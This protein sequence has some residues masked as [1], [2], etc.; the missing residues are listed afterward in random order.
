[1]DEIEISRKVTKQVMQA[2]LELSK[3]FK[4]NEEGKC[5]E[6]YVPLTTLIDNNLSKTP[7]NFS[8]IKGVYKSLF[9]ISDSK[10]SCH[11]DYT[12]EEVVKDFKM[13]M[14]EL[15]VIL[16]KVLV[17]LTAADK[18][19]MSDAFTEISEKITMKTRK[20]FKLQ[21]DTIYKFLPRCNFSN[22]KAVLLLHKQMSNYLDGGE[23]PLTESMTYGFQINMSDAVKNLKL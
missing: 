14:E 5:S 2:A 12:I 19:T 18:K 9:N 11:E 16:D 13:A 3:N 7:L 8:Y 22:Q 4:F 10:Y 21:I 6:E 1:M 15:V 17:P 23:T 20:D